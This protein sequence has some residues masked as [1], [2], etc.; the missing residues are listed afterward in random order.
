M[1]TASLPF[2][3]LSMLADKRSRQ[4]ER[5]QLGK[6]QERPS[7]LPVMNG[8]WAWAGTNCHKQHDPSSST[9]SVWLMVS[10]LPKTASDLPGTSIICRAKTGFSL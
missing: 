6:S 1:A 7:I 9:M 2:E 3:S 4:Q 8:R 10:K 5:C